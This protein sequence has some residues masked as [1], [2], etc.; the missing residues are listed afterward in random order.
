VA[1]FSRSSTPLLSSMKLQHGPTVPELEVL[2]L[3]D[4]VLEVLDQVPDWLPNGDATPGEF[5]SLPAY[6][7]PLRSL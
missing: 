4:Q 3:V 2:D 1:T 7:V 6:V 5:E